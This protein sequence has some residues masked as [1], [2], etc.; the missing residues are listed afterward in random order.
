ME[1]P[2]YKNHVTKKK[3]KSDFK[4]LKEHKDALFK[5]DVKGKDI[6]KIYKIEYLKYVDLYK[7]TD[8]FSEDIRVKCNFLDN[9]SPHEFVKNNEFTGKNTY[10]NLDNWIYKNTRCCSN[11]PITMALNVYRYFKPKYVL[12]FSAGWGDRLIA[13][14]AYGC[15][16]RGVDPNKN[17]SKKYKEMINFFDKSEN[18]YSVEKIGFENYDVKED[19]KWGEYDLVFTSP[20]F[21]DLERYSSDSTQSNVKYKTLSEWKEDFF[22]KCL[23]KSVDA[24]KDGGNIALYINDY[25]GYKF[26]G[27]SIRYMKNKDGVTYEGSIQWIAERYPKKIHVFSVKK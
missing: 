17:M 10:E 20:P 23:D 4:A 14:M 21:F 26:V 27:D 2:Y 12:D 18:K 11:F 6:L 7:I 3:I 1:Y 22:Y 25:K 15:H 16:Y 9:I 24:V 8:Y 5:G 19:E 13:A